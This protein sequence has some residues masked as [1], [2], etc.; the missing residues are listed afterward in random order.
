[1]PEFSAA[2]HQFIERALEL[3]L[4]PVSAPHPNPR[5][6]CVIVQGDKIVGEGFHSQAGLAHAEVN[7]LDACGGLAQDG[8]MY[9]T[10]EPCNVHGRT[11]PCVDRVIQSGVRRVV[12]CTQDPNPSVSGRGIQMLRDA[13]II[14]QVGLKDDIARKINRGFFSRHGRG[15]AWTT[16]KVAST[17]DGRIATATGESA[18][19]T[20][21]ASRH[22]VQLLRAQTS[23]ILTGIG[24]VQTDNPRL[25]CRAPGAT[26]NPTR[27][28]VDSNLRISPDSRLFEV[29]SDVIIATKKGVVS[30][31][32]SELE[33]SAQITEFQS[34]RNGLDCK[35]LLEYL[36]RCEFNEVL[37]EAGSKLVGSLLGDRLIDEV[38][39]YIAP[40]FIG[41]EGIGIAE[42][43]EI[44]RLS[45]RIQ[46][47]FTEVK[48]IGEDLKITIEL[49]RSE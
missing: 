16:V 17:L 9:V 13:G 1:M 21:E 15:M 31:N 44:V 8:V 38:I 49:D 27:V 32:R 2:D 20:G 6:G 33:K 35:E 24:T 28:V 3:A 22:D 37:V 48:R 11:P 4:V 7:A 40:S 41:D 5:V 12:V 26:I 10:L 46:A 36:T 34:G 39:L 18:W 25:N 23:A 14:T 30:E 29:D 19:I 43:P 45:D 47:K 42:L